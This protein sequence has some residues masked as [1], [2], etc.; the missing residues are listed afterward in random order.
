[1]PGRPAAAD[2]DEAVLLS[3]RR[4]S[5]QLIPAA[6]TASSPS[7]MDV[8]GQDRSDE[9][10]HRDNY[11][12]DGGGSNNHER[13]RRLTS[14]RVDEVDVFVDPLAVR[15]TRSGERRR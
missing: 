10:S 14:C 3:G 9:N 11:Q 6:S 5:Q 1:V 7:G 13:P 12:D 15:R 4:G 8:P 2:V